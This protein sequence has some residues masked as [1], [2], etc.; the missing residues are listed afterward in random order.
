MIDR[1]KGICDAYIGSKRII[2]QV[3][4]KMLLNIGK[5]G[6]LGEPGYPG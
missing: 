3:E 1:G 2:G 5:K 4:N 6:G